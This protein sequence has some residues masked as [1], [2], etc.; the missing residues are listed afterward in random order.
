[1][2]LTAEDTA[3]TDSTSITAKVYGRVRADILTGV[4]EPGQKLKIDELRQTYGSGSSPIREALSLLTSDKLVERVDQR[5]FRVA[6]VS[7]EAFDELLTTRC[8][9]EER[10][11][12]ES[13]ARGDKDW[14]ERVV[15]AEYHLSRTE[16]STS[17]NAFIANQEWERRHKAFHMALISASGSSILLNFCDQLYDQNIR[18]RHVAGRVAYPKRNI[19]KEHKAI[20]QAALDRD[21]TAAVASLLD[22]YQGTGSFLTKALPSTLSAP[23]ESR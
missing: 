21:A 1:V 4:F 19:E 22:H 7:A 15:L 5:G 16:R 11:L 2:A 9:L 8:W 10:A 17:R 12:S 20:M 13:I 14:E 3:G 18:Y 6:L 23:A